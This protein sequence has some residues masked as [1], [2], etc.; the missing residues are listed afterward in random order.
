MRIDRIDHLVLTVADVER[1][2]A[3]YAGALGMEAVTFGQGRHALAFGRANIGLHLAGHEF[4]PGPTHPTRAAPT[5]SSLRRPRCLDVI[6]ELDRHGVEIV[7]GPVERVGAT[8]TMDSVSFRFP[9]SEPDRDEQL[10]L[11]GFRGFAPEAF[12]WFAGLERDN[13]KAYFTAT[14]ERYERDVRGDLEALLDELAEEL[15]GSVK[16]FRQQRDLRFT[17]DKTPYK[18][19]TYGVIHADRR[20]LYAELSARGLYAGT[21]YHQL[22]RDQLERF[23]AGVADDARGAA[24]VALVA[25]AEEAGLEIEGEALRTAPRGYPRDHPARRAAAPQGADRRPPRGAGREGIGRE[26]ALAARRRDVAGRGAA[27]RVARRARRAERA[28]AAPPLSLRGAPRRPGP[29]LSPQHDGVAD[30]HAARLDR[31]AVHAEAGLAL[32]GD[33]LQD[34]RLPLVRPRVDVDHHAARIALVDAHPQAADPQRAADPAVLRERLRATGAHQQV[35]P[36][37]LDLELPADQRPDP[38]DAV[39]GDQAQRQPVEHPAVLLDQPHAVAERGGQRRVGDVELLALRGA[40]QGRRGVRPLRLGEPR[41]RNGAAA[42]ARGWSATGT[43]C[44]PGRG[45]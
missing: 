4:E 27:E 7:E 21:G 28:R 37:A 18:T 30:G 10:P 20:G 38:A 39:R 26:A 19:R 3:F 31:R 2:T 42:A 32:A 41:R 5:S 33:R 24:L 9:A 1:T 34:R 6:A 15:G 12:A 11:M 25:A 13:S 43:R 14:R 45:G 36:E 35:R 29:A 17:P 8:S 23:R 22:A 16:V 40:H 44:A